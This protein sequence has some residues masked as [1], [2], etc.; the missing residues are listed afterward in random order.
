M[1]LFFFYDHFGWGG[2]VSE[3]L[4]GCPHNESSYTTSHGSIVEILPIAKYVYFQWT[5]S[6]LH[7]FQDTVYTQLPYMLTDRLML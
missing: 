3:I 5:H 4:L 7:L 1:M 6:V 2:V